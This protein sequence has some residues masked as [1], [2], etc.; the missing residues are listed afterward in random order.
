MRRSARVFLILASVLNGLAGLVCGVLFVLSPDGS[1]MGFEPLVDVVRTL[2]LADVFFRDLLWIGIAM[3][4]AL[5]LPNAVATVMLLRRSSHQYA[6]TLLAGVLL[7]LWTG[8][9]I[10][11]MFNI[12][13]LVYFVVGALAVLCSVMLRRAAAPGSA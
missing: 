6:L 1:L 12:A 10:V 9:E 3:L 2:P 13:A 5:G 4:L 8:F 11:F 7:M